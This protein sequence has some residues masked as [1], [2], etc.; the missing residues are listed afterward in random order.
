MPYSKKFSGAM[1]QS[2]FG[3]KG[4]F[5]LAVPCNAGGMSFFWRNNDLGYMPWNGPFRFGSGNIRG[6]SMIQG[7]FGTKGNLELIAVEGNRLVSYWRMDAAPWTWN[8]PTVVAANGCQGVPA[9]IQSNYGTKGNLEVVV[10]RAAGG[11][12]HFWRTDAA[13]WTW[14]GPTAF[15]SGNITG[16]AMI[17]SNY[18]SKGNLEVVAVEGN[19]LVLYWRMDAAPWTWHGPFTIAA[20]GV[21]GS[22]AL[23]QSSFGTKGNFEV[24]VPRVGGGLSLFWRN[25]D[26]ANLPWNGP[27]NFGSGDYTSVSLVQSNYGGGNLEVAALRSDGRVDHYWRETGPNWTW[28]GPFAIPRLET[29]RMHIKILTN[30]TRFSIQQMVE[31][32]QEIY[33]GAG[34]RVEWAS[35]ENLNL[36]ALNDLDLVLPNGNSCIRGSVSA[37]QTEIFN[38]RNN[39]T[40][41]DIVVYFVNSTA[42]ALNGCASHPAGRP[43]AVVTRGASRFTL[44]HEV[45]HVLGLSHVNDS[46]RLMTGGGTDNITNLPPDLI[47]S[48]ITTMIGSTLTVPSP[49]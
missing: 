28:H 16:V 43:G 14:T 2:T 15:G 10:P 48:E 32:M 20:S 8:G 38:N 29:L 13:P 3:T 37:E 39:V 47:A 27:F 26:L 18:G 46:N 45:G 34:I 35:T 1:V 42:P 21:K 36:P 30:P 4:N 44:A 24:I 40:G 17:Q 9:L 25:N 6:V 49:C 31:A 11:L 33:Y 12:A 23:I 7:N 22:P 19:K 41:N 5:E